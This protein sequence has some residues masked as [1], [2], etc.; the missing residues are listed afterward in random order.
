MKI[1]ID[2]VITL[3]KQYLGL[4]ETTKADAILRK[5]INMA[6]RRLDS[7]ATYVISCETIDIDCDK[8]KLPDN[9]IEVI[10]FRFPGVT[11]SGCCAASPNTTPGT[12]GVNMNPQCGCPVWYIP[13]R[14]VLTDWNGYGANAAWSTSYF[15]FDTQAG[16]IYFPSTVTATQVQVYYRGYNEASNGIM[17]IEEYW[18][19]GLASFAAFKYASSGTNPLKYTTDQ[20]RGWNQTWVKQ[21]GFIRGTEN[22]IDSRAHKADLS[23]IARAVLMN[24]LIVLNHNP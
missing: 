16:Y 2:Q 1:A 6:A 5:Y 19:D 24:P 4:E 14:D 11:C 8:A 17:M 10:S 13:N 18:E 22:V 3:A 21:K 12:L 20:R 15:S 23:A 7:R 9:T